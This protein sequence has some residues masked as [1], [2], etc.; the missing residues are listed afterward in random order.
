MRPHARSASGS[1]AWFLQFSPRH[2]CHASVPGALPALPGPASPGA[3]TPEHLPDLVAGPELSLL[4]GGN[5]HQ[6]VLGLPMVRKETSPGGAQEVD[7]EGGHFGPP[8]PA[9]P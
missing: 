5:L 2:D 8:L 7:E 4:M 6:E 1:F 3:G 9:R